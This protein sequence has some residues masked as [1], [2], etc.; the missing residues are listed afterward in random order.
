MKATGRIARTRAF[1]EERGLDAIVVRSTSDLMW[2]TGFERVFDT[3]QA[4]VAVVTGELCLLHTDSRYSTA[5]R[6]RSACEGIWEIDDKPCKTADFVAA[7]LGDAGL[8]QGRV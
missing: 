5:M 7:A 8:S 1:M 3:E 4:H 2:L 6:T